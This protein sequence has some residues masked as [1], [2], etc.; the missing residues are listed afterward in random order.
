VRYFNLK[1]GL[2]ASLVNRVQG[3]GYYTLR[4]DRGLLRSGVY[5]MVFEAGSFVRKLRVAVVR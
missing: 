1:G 3:P 2:A 5:C 4:I